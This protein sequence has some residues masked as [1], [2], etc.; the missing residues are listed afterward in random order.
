LLSPEDLRIRA[1]YD[2]YWY[3]GRATLE[4]LHQDLRAT[5]R[6]VRPD[7]DAPAS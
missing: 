6:A 2:G 7:F 4:E 1:V 3:S 5:Q